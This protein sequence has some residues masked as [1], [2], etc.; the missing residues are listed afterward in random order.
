M[1]QVWN[2]KEID[3]NAL[4]TGGFVAFLIMKRLLGGVLP[5]AAA[6]QAFESQIETVRGRRVR[7]T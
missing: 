6:P 2:C 4:Q 7:I 3:V 1:E 5:P